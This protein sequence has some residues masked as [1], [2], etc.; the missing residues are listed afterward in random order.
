MNIPIQ[1]P[2][3][4]GLVL[5]MVRKAQGVRA[6]DLAGSAGVGPVFVLDVEN[7]KTTVQLGKVL[8]VLQEAGI[9]V[10]LELPDHLDLS[11]VRPVSKLQGDERREQLLKHWGNWLAHFEEQLKADPA[12]DP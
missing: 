4:L 12:R 10:Q 5:R 1:T 7:G 11:Q 8:Q 6:D 2:A 9:G 3:E